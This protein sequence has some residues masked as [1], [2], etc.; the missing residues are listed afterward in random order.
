VVGGGGRG[1]NGACMRVGGVGSGLGAGVPWSSSRTFSATRPFLGTASRR[2][3]LSGFH[4]S[5][6]LMGLVSRGS[7]PSAPPGCI[8]AAGRTGRRG[9]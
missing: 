8:A 5:V 1:G 3:A 7:G 9:G 4:V 6:L 2:R